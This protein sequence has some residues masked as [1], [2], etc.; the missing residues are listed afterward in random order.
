LRHMGRWSGLRGAFAGL[1]TVPAPLV[2]GA[3]WRHAG[4][5]YVFLI[6]VVLDLA[7]RLPLLATVPE[8]LQRNPRP[9]R[10]SGGGA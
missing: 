10:H 3:V 6:P 4:P 9:Y 1:V 5:A 2:G 8:T 7:L